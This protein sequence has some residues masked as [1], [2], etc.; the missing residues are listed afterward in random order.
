MNNEQ[1]AEHVLSKVAA[2]QPFEPT[3]YYDADGDCIEFIA[4]P[5][6]YYAERVD[7]LVTVYR[8]Q[9]TDEIIGSLLKGVSRFLREVL[10]RS[11][12]FKFEIQDGRMKLVHLFTAKLW[13]EAPDPNTVPG[14][15]YRK[16]RQVAEETGAEVEMGDLALT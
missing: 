8:S 12:G 16:L 2:D 6:S 11:P 3:A 15:T 13:T 7:T 1:F 10:R 5:D 9:E 14:L 4:A